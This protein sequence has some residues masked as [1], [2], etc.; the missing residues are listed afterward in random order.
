MLYAPLELTV[1]V[2]GLSAAQTVLPGTIVRVQVRLLL[3]LQIYMTSDHVTA[4]RSR[5]RDIKLLL[6]IIEHSP[7]NAECTECSEGTYAASSGAVQCELCPKDT[8]MDHT[9]ATGNN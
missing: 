8:Y 3:E 6:V 5:H 2:Q 1:T 9:A 7:G 4:Q